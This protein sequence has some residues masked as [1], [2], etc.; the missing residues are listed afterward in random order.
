MAKKESRTSQEIQGE[1]NAYKQL[2]AN[3]DYQA[4]KHSEG[5]ISDADYEE[6][7]DIRKGYRERINELEEELASAEE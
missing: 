3:T 2:L 1:I 4:I 7:K 5:K 6:M